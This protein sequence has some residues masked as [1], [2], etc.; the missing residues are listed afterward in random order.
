MQQ[1][2]SIP[3]VL[4]VALGVCLL[5]PA[6]QAGSCP[7]NLDRA[8]RLV[9]VTA[10]SMGS[11]EAS[12]RRYERASPTA[13]WSSQG[14]SEPAV[15][16][17][18]GLGW[19]HPFA[20]HAQG[21]EPLKQEGDMRTP[22]GIYPLGATFGFAKDRRPNYLHLVPGANFCVHDTNSPLYGRIV[23]RS[24]AGNNVSGEDM[25]AIPGYRH[26]V[27][28]DYP[29][30]RAA[31][32]GSCVFVH[33]WNGEGVGTAGCVALPEE[34]VAFLQDWTKGRHA[35]IVSADTAARF[36]ECLPVGTSVSG[37]AE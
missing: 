33:I 21:S 8:T 6:A 13:S 24:T 37:R 16:G 5:A 3:I 7:A 22:A 28:I 2:S 14:S 11:A 35:A 23:P 9:I 31:K 26:G 34:R 15:I 12:L 18:Q 4:T 19:G 30:N 17:A 36:S 29:P 10:P 32:A 25:S 20:G 27:V 1:N